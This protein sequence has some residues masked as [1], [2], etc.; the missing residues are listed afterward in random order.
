MT[1]GHGCSALH[2]GLTPVEVLWPLSV[3]GRAS[4][5]YTTGEL[6]ELTDGGEA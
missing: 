3:R 4:V 5:T 1:C 2:F 6:D